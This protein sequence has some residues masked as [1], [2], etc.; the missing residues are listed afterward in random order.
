M[1]IKSEDLRVRVAPHLREKLKAIAAE[2]GESEASVIRSAVLA[3]LDRHEPLPSHVT[4]LGFHEPSLLVAEPPHE[5]G[6]VIDPA[7]AGGA[8]SAPKK[9]YPKG[10]AQKSSG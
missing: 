3:Y 8:G 10:K 4:H 5:P 1:G 6:K 2:I 7:A 9:K